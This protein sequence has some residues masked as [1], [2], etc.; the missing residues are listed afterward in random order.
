MKSEVLL[1]SGSR[2]FRLL[3]FSFLFFFFFFFLSLALSF[4]CSL[5]AWE[6]RTRNQVH[7]QVRSTAGSEVFRLAAV[8]G[9]SV[10]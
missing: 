10:F 4:P 7:E 2:R 9:L 1:H 5:S 6:R 8:L 3:L